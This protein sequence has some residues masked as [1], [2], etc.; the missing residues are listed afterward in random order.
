MKKAIET[1][2]FTRKRLA[3]ITIVLLIFA[4]VVGLYVAFH[5]FCHDSFNFAQDCKL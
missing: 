4:I 1:R 5:F 3:W 2:T